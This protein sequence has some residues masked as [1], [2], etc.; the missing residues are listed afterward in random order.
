MQR[1]TGNA[2]FPFVCYAMTCMRVSWRPNP[3]RYVIFARECQQ[4]TAVTVTEQLKGLQTGRQRDTGTDFIFF[5]PL[6]F[7]VREGTC[8]RKDILIN[9]RTSACRQEGDSMQVYR[10]MRHA[11]TFLWHCMTGEINDDDENSYRAASIYF[12]AF[13]PGTQSSIQSSTHSFRHTA[14]LLEGPTGQ[15]RSDLILP[16]FLL[17]PSETRVLNSRSCSFRESMSQSVSQSVSHRQCVS[18]PVFL[19]SLHSRLFPQSVN[20]QPVHSFLLN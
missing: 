16:A 7:L 18:F 17:L 10:L 3:K 4:G 20:S 12:S 19:V 1:T 6:P 8:R 2:H 5:L 11:H 15:D 9:K 14:C 13:F